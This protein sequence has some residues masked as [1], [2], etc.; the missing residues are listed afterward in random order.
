MLESTS[1]PVAL[2]ADIDGLLAAA[3]AGHGAR[4]P[5]VWPP[6]LANATWDRV[7]FHGIALALCADPAGMSHWPVGLADRIRS[8]ARQQ[9]FWEESHRRVVAQVLTRLHE[10]RVPCLVLKGTALAYLV[11]DEP[12]TRRRGDSDL[13]VRRT[14]LRTVRRILDDLGWARSPD[15]HFGQEDWRY[16]TGMGFVHVIDLH[17]EVANSPFLRRVL[18]V[19]E[20]FASAIPLPRLAPAAQ[21]I[22]PA[23]LLLRGVINQAMHHQHGYMVER[24]RVF[25]EGRLIWQLD[26]HL[27]AARFSPDDW[28]ELARIAAERGMAGPC[29]AALRAAHA[30]F[31]TP[32]PPQVEQHLASQD[33]DTPVLRYLGQS[34]A[35]ER[36]A[37]DLRAAGTWRDYRALLGA[38]AFPSRDFMHERYP[39]KRGWPLA[40]L[41]V[42][43]VV[44]GGLRRLRRTAS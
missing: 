35:Q 26:T 12:A 3:L 43:R 40:V 29:L 25:D 42:H 27:L 8:E 38:H 24:D 15:I 32:V 2:P 23:L 22:A 39:T 5:E 31:G 28:A 21:T 37:Q 30:T 41:Y 11:H 33:G 44:S 1:P 34:S 13:L 7:R 10:A 20:C 18:D 19:E 16:D 9:V 17:W 4:W 14:Q 36:F 6:E